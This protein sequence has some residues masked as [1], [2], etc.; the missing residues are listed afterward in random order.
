MA[1]T[2]RFHSGRLILDLKYATSSA[3]LIPTPFF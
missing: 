2:I 1:W 3:S